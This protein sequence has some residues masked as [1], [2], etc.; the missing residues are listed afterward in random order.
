VSKVFET[1]S[2]DFSEWF[3][4]YNYDTLNYDQTKLLCNRSKTDGAAPKKGQV[5]ELGYYDIPTG[6]WHHIGDS[7]SWNWQQGAMMQ[8]LPGKG[9]E[10]K[11]I[12]NTSK[13]GHLISRIHDIITGDEKDISWS[14]YGITPDGKK[15]IA[16]DLERSHWCRAYHYESVANLE[17]EGRVYE[18]DGIFEI[19]LQK[20]TRKKIISIQDIIQTD[21]RPYFEE[22]K[23][24]IEHIMINPSGT[25][26][27]FLH[28]FSSMA[29]V[30]DYT[31][32]LMIADIDGNN[33]Q[34]IEGWD[35]VKWSHFGWNGDD[36]FAIYTYVAP[37]LKEGRSIK[38]LLT[39][40]SIKGLSIKVFTAINK[41]LPVS[42]SKR[43]G[44]AVSYY[45]YYRVVESGKFR[46]SS[47]INNS[48]CRIDGHPS[49]SKS[50]QFMLTDTYGDRKSW[51]SLY[52]FN[53]LN[54]KSM[55]LGRFYAY[56]NH[57][58]SSCDLHP[59]LC[60]NNDFVVV[61]TA[62]NEKHHMIVLKIDWSKLR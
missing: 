38:T 32:R 22:Q 33:L 49:F 20:N 35:K 57:K 25:R 61:D 37:K 62:Y 50:G 46:L 5:I 29:N 54:K 34:C 8:W 27:C 1:P 24:W 15:S 6:G 23:H 30:M 58:P 40:L 52:V 21:Y 48:I 2:K 7:D 13:N 53:M 11:V 44:A 19:D 45:Q 18:D 3:G 31:T 16:L 51:Q 56:Y 14:I 28:R 17:K 39:S 60:G 55:T 41:V 42:M 4:Y 47:D 12:Y 43:L 10:N 36:A 26:F 9:N 59:K